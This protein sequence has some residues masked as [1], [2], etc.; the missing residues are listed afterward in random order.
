MKTLAS[1]LTLFAIL[2]GSGVAM[3]D[4]PCKKD[5]DKYCAGKVVCGKCACHACLN[6][7]MA[8]LD[9]KCAKAM[10]KWDEKEEAKLSKAAL[11]K[12]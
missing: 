1:V 8:D 3:A 4:H 6:E 7:H 9:K 5:F 2:L 12:K 11:P 10:E